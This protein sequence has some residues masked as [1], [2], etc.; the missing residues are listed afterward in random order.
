MNAIVK[1]QAILQSLDSMN[2]AEMDDVLDYIKQMLYNE[3]LDRDYQAFKKNAMD[4][5]NKALHGD[6]QLAV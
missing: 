2:T 6:E 4:Q 3:H 5:I 1:K